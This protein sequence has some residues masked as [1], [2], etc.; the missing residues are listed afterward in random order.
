MSTLSDLVTV[1]QDEKPFVDFESSL[2]KDEVVAGYVPVKSTLEVLRF[3]AEATSQASPKGRAVICHGAYGSGKSRLCTVLAR[4]F[5]DGFECPA[6]SPI[7]QRLEARGETGALDELKRTMMPGAR[8]WRPWLVVPMY[9]Q[10]GGG[11]LGASLIRALVKAVRRHGLDNSVLGTT[12]YDAAITRLLEMVA[13]GAQYCAPET[14]PHGTVQQLKRALEDLDEQALV[15][16]RKFHT[17]ATHGVGFDEWLQSS[18][19]AALETHDVFNTV[20]ERIQ[21]RGFE[22]IVV[23]WDEF[24]FAIEELLRD[25]RRGIRG[26]GQET[27]NLQSFL[28]KSCGS[29]E[30]GKRVVFLG[31][32][33]FSISEYGTREGLEAT[34]LNRLNTVS[35]RFRSPSIV[36]RLSVTET[37]GYH[38]LAGMLRRTQEG[39]HVFGNP[40]PRLQHLAE[41]M[42]QLKPWARMAPHSCYDDISA[43]CYPLHP[44]ASIALLMLSDQIAQVNRTT[45]YFLQNRE[46]GGLAGVLDQRQKPSLD[47][48]GGAELLRVADLFPFFEQPIKE[49]K[50]HLHDQYQEALARFPDATEQDIRILRSTLILSVI[51]TP[52]LAPST[53]L[54]AFCVT[55]VLRSEVGANPLHEALNRLS[56]SGAL[57]KNDATDVW[58]FVGGRGLGAG[59]DQEIEDEIALVPVK[60]PARLLREYPQVQM[61]IVDLLG[62]FDLDPCESGVVRRIGIRILDIRKGGDAIEDVNPACD[63]TQRCWRSALIYLVVVGSMTELD[64]WRQQ[65]RTCKKRNVYFVVPPVPLAM[66]GEK[67]RK[68][69]AVQNLLENEPDD[70]HKHEVLD[71]KLTRLRREL[72]R[73]FEQL[74]GNP[75]LQAGTSV[76]K[77]DSSGGAVAVDSWNELLPSLAS[78]LESD[79]DKGI[80]VR[81][82]TFNEWQ[83]NTTWTAIDHVVERVLKFDDNPQWQKQYLGFSDT[84]QE[85]AVIDG[86]LVENGFLSQNALTE[87]WELITV[88][89]NTQEPALGDI[90]RHFQT[91]GGG[92]KEFLRLYAKLID[93]PHGI[94]NGVLPLLVALVFRTE[95]R[96]IGVYVRRA[97][98]VQRVAESQVASAIVEMAKA[99]TRYQT[100]FNKLSGKQRTVFRVLGPHMNVSFSESI[101]RGE[102]FYG[103]C[104]QV[105]SAIRNWATGLPDA[106]L[107]ATEL[108]E[109]QQR[110]LKLLRG[111]IS[112]QLPALAD[113][114]VAM[115]EED[116][117]AFEELGATAG[118][119]DFP[120]ISQAWR[121][122]R[123]KI[124]R[125]VEGVRAPLR[126]QIREI[127]GVDTS[128]DRKAFD[129]LASTLKAI[130]T[131][132]AA[133]NP[134]SR[135]INKLETMPEGADCLD[136]VAAAIANKTA[137]TLTQEDYG[138]ALGTLKMAEFCLAEQEARKATLSAK[139]GEGETK[140]GGEPSEEGDEPSEDAHWT[141]TPTED[142]IEVIIGVARHRLLRT[143][144]QEALTCI[145]ADVAKWRQVLRLDVKELAFLAV[146]ALLIDKDVRTADP[147]TRKKDESEV[148]P[149]STDGAQSNE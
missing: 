86:V 146:T 124:D 53:D 91:S 34:D 116:A 77:A 110:L 130:E 126:A 83:T 74:F 31:F 134:L 131:H 20:A 67:L 145:R 24:G 30:L 135:A 27:M 78:D 100:R 7:W 101:S 50:P 39:E 137:A 52:D 32:T 121:R 68:L 65:A 36:I 54:L 37:E 119:T 70:T 17:K 48:I 75:G 40:I 138:N 133:D 44:A 79:F 28:E 113:N 129:K 13:D 143:V 18:G 109:N 12:I 141:S 144:N 25:S 10:A 56:E 72:R 127:S 120:N 148:G 81:C 90:L 136:E 88:D 1:S 21:Q 4:L 8:G 3:L 140:N 95:G 112:P 15:T 23:I 105:R 59:I 5:S 103:Y 26:L 82:G 11:T 22:G 6:L 84:S 61:E 87:K 66:D 107:T 47:E 73:D 51:A 102:A 89:K 80:R 49:R 108:T 45:H 115:F 117:S 71:A 33:H 99:P 118:T 42:P 69:I 122:I 149:T 147:S 60:D 35:D 43:P 94:P 142:R 41:R 57:W 92:D 111:P 55:D 85:A 38:L 96:R 98:Q 114:L 16:F 123:T 46:E 2:D 76:V 128:E 14:S 93:T 19:G 64:Y 62:E 97:T 132:G 106:V 58:A 29:Q 104:E 9:A 63:G 139:L 125:Y